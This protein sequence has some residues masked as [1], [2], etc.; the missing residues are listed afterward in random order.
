[1]EET[2]QVV[3]EEEILE[4]LANLANPNCKKC[5][6]TGRLGW[7]IDGGNREVI[8]CIARN[9]ALHKYHFI[10]LMKKREEL[11]KQQEEEKNKE[12]TKEETNEKDS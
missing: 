11:I 3:S 1:M 4:S 9:C 2:K 8:P 10:K 12:A 6:G 5:N 7:R